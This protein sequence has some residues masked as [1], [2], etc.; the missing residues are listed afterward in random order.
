MSYSE[1]MDIRGEVGD[2]SVTI[3]KK[4]RYVDAKKCTACDLCAEACVQRERIPN[5]FDMGM[6]KRSAAFI[7]FPQA[8]PQTYVI[9]PNNCL[10]LTR[11]KCGKEPK[12]QKACGVN[13][14]D[15]TQQEE[16]ITVRVGAIVVA[17]GYDQFDPTVKPEYGYGRYENV[18]SG[19]EFERL[20]SASG[21]TKGEIIVNGEKPKRVVFIQCVGSRDKTVG[22][23]YCSRVCCMYAV[24]QAHLVREH[25]PDARITVCYMDIRAFGKGYEEF[26]D[27]VQ[28]ENILF[29]RGNPPEVYRRGSSLVVRG[30]DTL[31][32]ESYE[33]EADLVV[34]ATGLVARKDTGQ[35]G[36]LLGLSQTPDGFFEEA[37]T[38]ETIAT[39]RAGIFLAG[40]CQSPKDIPD[41]VAQASGAASLACVQ[42]AK[43]RS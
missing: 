14:I 12:C 2:F 20:C 24:K 29:R 11:E 15:F 10:M 4:P 9:D 7:P 41:T 43:G 33:E 5:E 42:L 32:A 37:Q 17:T 23:E 39:S 16:T 38:E 34:L 18:L 26:Y 30:E 19:I 28:G 6:G 1:V 21:P 27:R 40:C 3:K 35:I 25:I 22:N 36:K 31:L 8:V 13:A